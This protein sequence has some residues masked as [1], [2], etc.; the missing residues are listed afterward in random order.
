MDNL[1]K[2][3]RNKQNSV[4]KLN[5]R[6]AELEKKKSEWNKATTQDEKDKLETELGQAKTDKSNAE[7]DLS[8][9][10]QK[11]ERGGTPTQGRAGT[12]GLGGEGGDNSL[13][14]LLD[15]GYKGLKE[16]MHI[17]GF[18]DYSQNPFVKSA[19]AVLSFFGGLLGGGGPGK[20]LGGLGGLGGIAAHPVKYALGGF[21]QQ[22]VGAI[23]P[24]RSIVGDDNGIYG[25]GILDEPGA[26]GGLSINPGE[27]GMPP[28]NP[29]GRTGLNDVPASPSGYSG[30]GNY[31]VNVYGDVGQPA[32][33]GNLQRD[34][35]AAYVRAAGS[36]AQVAAARPGQGG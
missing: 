5:A 8:K 30:G 21:G 18:A 12:G 33:F 11:L 9:L 22:P 17:P 25:S 14:S 2:E 16:T 19:G 1:N 32:D 36:F 13:S 26:H 6:I 20:G 31:N 3:I 35:R 24:G 29:S 27:N 15:I 10:K 4:D 28:P 23:T 34:Q 7:D